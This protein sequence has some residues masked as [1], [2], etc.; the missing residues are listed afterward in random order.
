MPMKSKVIYGIYVKR[1][2]LY[3]GAFHFSESSIF[4]EVKGIARNM[5]EMTR[6]SASVKN[7]IKLL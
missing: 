5:R 6:V 7:A 2:A 1:L 3:D 4:F